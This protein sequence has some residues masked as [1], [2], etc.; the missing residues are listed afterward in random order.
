MGQGDRFVAMGKAHRSDGYLWSGGSFFGSALGIVNGI[1]GLQS[2]QDGGPGRRR[3][4]GGPGETQKPGGENLGGALPHG[5]AVDRTSDKLLQGRLVLPDG[6]GPDFVSQQAGAQTIAEES[7]LVGKAV[8]HAAGVLVEGPSVSSVDPGI[9]H[10][11]KNRSFMI[12]SVGGE[13]KRGS[14]LAGGTTEETK[15]GQSEG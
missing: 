13:S 15:K 10:S 11:D 7:R 1:G 2:F 9:G 6:H 14:Q 3:A 5:L 12:R 4:E 8:Y